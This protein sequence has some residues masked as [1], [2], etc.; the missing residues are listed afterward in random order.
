MIFRKL[1]QRISRPKR[2]SFRF[3]DL[4]HV[5]RR[6]SDPSPPRKV[7]QETLPRD[8]GT[9]LSKCIL[10]LLAA[11]PYEWPSSLISR[12]NFRHVYFLRRDQIKARRRHVNISDR[13]FVLVPR[14]CPRGESVRAAVWNASVA[15]T[16]TPLLAVL[17]EGTLISSPNLKLEQCR[18]SS[19]ELFIC[20]RHRRN[21]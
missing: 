11:L 17:Q 2:V 5:C 19:H 10:R 8:S 18:N 4:V 15:E 1:R 12:D 14:N 3:L 16:S 7:E 13:Q 6:N 21:T 9:T 20:F